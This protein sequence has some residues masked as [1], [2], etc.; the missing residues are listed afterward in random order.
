MHHPRTAKL[1]PARTLTRTAPS[2]FILPGAMTLKAREVELGRRLGEREVARAETGDGI[3]AE[4]TPQP[5]GDCTFQ[6]GHRDPLVDAQA[7]DL[8]E[9]RRVCHIRRVP[10]KHAPRGE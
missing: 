8:V 5:F 6:M 2:V 9:H 1:Y 7:F 10:P 4:Q 3:L